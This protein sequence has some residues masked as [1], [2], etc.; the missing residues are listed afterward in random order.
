VAKGFLL[1]QE[2]A[3]QLIIYSW[4]LPLGSGIRPRRDVLGNPLCRGTIGQRTSEKGGKVKKV[5]FFIL[6]IVAFDGLN[7]L[8]EDVEIE[9]IVVTADRYAQ[10]MSKV[11]A[12]VS[13]ISEEDIQSSSAQTIPD[14]LRTQEGIVVRDYYG[15]GSKVS[16]DLRGFGETSGSNSLVLVD[17]RRINEIDLS[18][19][20]WTQIPVDAV[21]RIEIMRGPGSVLYGDNAVGGVVNIITKTGKG[22][23]AFEL[24][25]SA[26]SYQM[27][28][29]QISVSGSENKLSYFANAIRQS[30][31]G[32][33]NNSYYDADYFSGKLAY[34]LSEIINLSL[35]GGFHDA[36]YGLPGALRASELLTCSRRDSKF[37]D[38]DAGEK[39]FYISLDEKTKIFDNDELNL[40]ASFRSR[41]LD[42]YWGTGGYGMNSS[43][44]DT[45]GVCP[46]LVLNSKI[47]SKSNALIMGFDF[48][49][50]D[51]VMNDFSSSGSQTG[52]A[53][54]D[55][56]SY[57]AYLQDKFSL[58]DKL[59]LNAGY[60]FE[61][62]KYTFRYHDL[63]HSFTDIDDFAEFEMNLFNFGVNYNYKTQSKIFFNAGKGFR[64]PATE[65]F[66]LYDFSA[67]P[68]GRRIN[69]DLRAQESWDF[70]IGLDHHLNPKLN[71]SATAF[72]M[73]IENEIY[74]NPLLYQNENY[75]KTQ[76]QG[77]EL[78]FKYKAMD[79][80][81]LSGNYS[82][83]QALFI[84]GAFDNNQIPA[85]PRHK[86][87]LSLKWKIIRGCQM[88]TVLNYTGKQYFISDQ[89]NA[90]PQMPDFV[91]VDTKVSILLGKLTLFTG[92]NNIFDE[93]YSEYGVISTTFNES[94][95]YP[96]PGRNFIFGGTLKF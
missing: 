16:V 76:R 24:T 81:D 67:F 89:A 28:K 46:K 63:T 92:I 18:G 49:R 44:I 3:H 65:E 29:Q 23:P 53:D 38:D 96:A 5:F 79:N 40:S 51:S 1:P 2:A 66:V 31:N 88:N 80:L 9:R 41:Y 83:V 13:I 43:R 90:Y 20:D 17:G 47:L 30:T 70:E 58:T 71:I 7:L 10:S 26:G 75:D 25:S 21:E 86:A 91:T 68:F 34:E 64:L 11:A 73:K 95:Y 22:K 61:N 84:E 12:S 94:G 33:R 59:Y 56:E 77:I 37:V 45:I 62:A 6:A 87:S 4:V 50:T 85:V 72:L 60:R 35:S 27:E 32:Y 74:Y 42:T 8:A 78:G 36:D 19:V 69:Q 82:F 54:V 15:S 39:D 52:D 14:L 93:E 48:Y 55:K 57:G